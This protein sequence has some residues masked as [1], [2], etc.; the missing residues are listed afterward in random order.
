MKSTVLVKS[1]EETDPG[2]GIKPDKRPIKEYI[3]KGII[4]L[5]KPSGPTSHQVAA[6]VK[7]ILHIEKAGHSG[8]LDPK[9]TGVLPI[10]L[11]DSTKILKTLLLAGKEYVTLM[12][13]HGEVKNSQL[14]KT[15][16]YFQGNIYQKPPLKSAVKRQ[17][18]T[19]K[20]YSIKLIERKENL[21]LFTV[22][23]EAGTYIRKLCHDIGL[24]CGTGA[25]MQNLRRIRVGPFTEEDLVTLHDLKDA[26]E[27]YC[28]N[29]EEKYLR[30]CIKPR[31]HG[32]RHLKKIWL[33]DTAISA[34][35]H[36]ADLNAPGI[37]KLDPGI[38]I[39]ELVALM[40]LKDELV[41]A[42]RS[43]KTSEEIME[44][45]KGKI[46][47]LE[48]VIMAPDTYPRK[49]RNHPDI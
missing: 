14:K 16:S 30:E 6:W 9:T 44:T 13:L 8:T 41:A 26:Y 42:G 48:R 12:S 5:D 27:F 10:A 28:E 47:D 17:I 33:K 18:R 46:T 19:K 15:L 43:L 37:S 34:I 25:H 20:I 31:E 32:I 4:N 2:Y 45:Q 7:E 36:G 21:V 11:A 3:L 38:E 23:C 29:G 40:S 24:I 39:N 35:C 49:W 22:D 1:D